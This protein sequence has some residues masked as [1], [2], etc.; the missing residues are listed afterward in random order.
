[1]APRVSPGKTWEG[2]VAGTAACIFV[3]WV[4]F[5][6]TGFMEG[7]RS[8]VL[9]GVV[10][11][12]AVLGDLFESAVKRDAGAKDSGTLLGGHGGMLDRI[13][14]PLFASCAAYYVI[15][16]YGLG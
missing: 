3:T 1:M 12:T 6:E 16:A 11:V 14:A 8:F 13:D 9:G 4:C 7:T 5:Y 2:F 10:A 15:V